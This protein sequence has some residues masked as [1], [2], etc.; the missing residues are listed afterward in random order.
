MKLKGIAKLIKFDTYGWMA[1]SSLIICI[2]SGVLLAIPY[3]VDDPYGSLSILV[4]ENPAGNLFRNLH[5]WSAQAFLILTIIHIFD[6][7]FRNTEE[8]LSRG[9]WLRLTLTVAIVF[10]AMLSGF[11]LKG[12]ADA[13]QAR[14]IF[15]GLLSGIPVVGY[16]LDYSL[17][18]TED[19]FQLIYV[20]HI[21]TATILILA[22]TYEHVRSIWPDL[23]R[24]LIAFFLL[25]I[26]S[27]F[28][29]AP[30]HDGYE[31][32]TKGPW[33]F[34][35]L[36]EILHWMAN[37]L[38]I[39][40][41]FILLFGLF[42]LVRELG[43][44]PNR[45]LKRSLLGIGLV[46][47]A[48]TLIGS[49]FRGEDWSWSLPAVKNGNQF[50]VVYHPINTSFPE[51]YTEGISL[52][53]KTGERFEGCMV[54]HDGM[55][56]LSASHDPSAIGCASCHGGDPFTM[57]KE[58]AHKNM[59][60]VP[61]N[62]SD[63]RRSCGTADCHPEIASRVDNSIM[64]TLSGMVSVNRY[65]FGE[66]ESLSVLSHIEQI[67]HTPADEHLRDL[68]AHCHLG[69]LK[70]EPGAISQLSRG[71]GCNACH[72]NYNEHSLKSLAERENWLKT[73]ESP[74][75]H[76]S[77]SVAISDDH[78]FGC[79]SRSGRIS[80][81]YR[82]LHESLMDPDKLPP[83]HDYTV[84]DDYRVMVG[85]P[86]DVHHQSG[87][88][89]ID[90]HISFG[91]MGDGNLYHHKEEQ[92]KIGCEDCH[93]YE[94]PEVVTT[95]Y[96]DY[97]AAKIAALRGFDQPGRLFIRSRK[98]GLAMVNTLVR[99]GKHFLRGKNNDTI[100]PLYPPADVCGKTEA[101]RNLD[102]N[103]CHSSWVPQCIGCHNAYDNEATGFDLLDYREK[104]GE[105]IEFV[106][107]YLAGQPVLGVL[108][109][110][111]ENKVISTFTPGMILTI[112]RSG[113]PGRAGD[114]EIFKRLHSPISPHTT[115]AGSR[116]CISCHLDPLAIGYGR[117][118]L[119]YNTEGG[120]GVFGFENKYAFR[121]EDGL[122]EDA[123]VPFMLGRTGQAATRPGARP[124]NLMEQKKIL[125]VG[126]CL[127]CHEEESE[128]MQRSLWDFSSVL[129]ERSSSCILPEWYSQD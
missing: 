24:F 58:R 34:T 76:P 25:I 66:S 95:G 44:G 129:E 53:E 51:E 36:Q 125:L 128:I 6:H 11:I 59:L 12:D 94:D 65:V 88:S 109:E 61:G 72:L 77:L 17:L 99:E 91:L 108:N 29:R 55:T 105:W 73:G 116:S 86:S 35:G 45:I 124:F 102:C 62:L 48:L 32:A 27:F 93:F 7:F 68:C 54:C 63:A 126:S 74:R 31:L 120:T 107:K 70:K 43:L 47:L 98:S 100:Y 96:L 3:D 33:Y 123:W 97:E 69:H 10:F 21:A 4:I 84:L 30:L 8:N 71:G 89:C 101:H 9:V 37:P 38:Q 56:G 122:P 121:E 41:V 67:G 18:G 19:D 104:K 2:I 75:H 82:G 110:D 79:H 83:G 26:I 40:W 23:F 117:G 57:N 119:V 16:Y 85:M 64:A 118:E 111:G 39:W 115:S 52:S 92:V 127:H 5:F 15:S 80:L 113:F 103:S 87:M 50:S 22:F 60:I 42:Y 114:P 13:L 112:D 1:V 46:Y 90:C 49:F 78:C 106:G 14:R 20:H 81:S 28:F